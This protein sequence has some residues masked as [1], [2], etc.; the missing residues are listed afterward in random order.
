[1]ALDSNCIFCKIIQGEIP[2]TKLWKP[3]VHTLS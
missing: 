1:M 3:N 2:S